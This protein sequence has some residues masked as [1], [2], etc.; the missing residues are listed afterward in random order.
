MSDSAQ[1]LAATDADLAAE[2]GAGGDRAAAAEAALCARLLPRIRLF[3]GRRLSDRHAVDDVAHEVLLS[4]LVALREG[5]VLDPESIG[6]FVLGTCRNKV[7]EQGRASRTS[8]LARERFPEPEPVPAASAPLRLGRLEECLSM[9][10]ERERV[11]L[12]AVFCEG[13]SSTET[14]VELGLTPANVR[15]LQHRA[16]SQLRTCVARARFEV[17]R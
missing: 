3:L 12:R 8:R 11:V 4:T 15:V 5:K 2:I 10:R 7:R 14:G 6:A 13:K 16:I 1:R 17:E 9:L